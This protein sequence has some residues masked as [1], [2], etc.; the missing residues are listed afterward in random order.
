[1]GNASTYNYPVRIK[2][3]KGS[4]DPPF[5]PYRDKQGNYTAEC[6]NFIDLLWEFEDEGVRAVTCACGFF[7]AAQQEAAAA[8]NIPV[9]TSPLLLIPFVHQM[10][11]PDQKVGVI[12]AW[13]PRLTD[14]PEIFLHPLG[15]TE[16]MPL[17]IIGLSQEGCTEFDEVIGDKR[18]DLHVE[19]LEE[20]V[21]GVAKKLVDQNPD[22]G[23]IVLECSDL[24]PFSAAI[25]EAI[26][27]PIFD[28]IGMIDMVHHAVVQ[29]RYQGF[30]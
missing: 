23:A 7:A 4:W 16:S 22:V 13:S 28:F 6:Q 24:P 5:P 25:Q 3:L 11:K 1:M 20:E 19:K 2:V 29:R 14:E 15:V 17:A 27:L 10:L 30:I 8:V 12:T 26:K 18:W 21:V 9:F